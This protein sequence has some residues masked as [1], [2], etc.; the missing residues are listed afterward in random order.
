MQAYSSRLGFVALEVEKVNGRVAG[1]S[2]EVHTNGPYTGT[3][4]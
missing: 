3:S 1:V 2:P 4:M